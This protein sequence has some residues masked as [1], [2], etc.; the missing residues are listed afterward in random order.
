MD[1]SEASTSDGDSDAPNLASPGFLERGANLALETMS[2]KSAGCFM[3][4]GT[5]SEALHNAS[6]ESRSSMTSFVSTM[7]DLARLK[8]LKTHTG[9]TGMSAI[10]ELELLRLMQVCIS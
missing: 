3:Q 9:C 7:S 6:G 5:Y 8:Y 1:A 10:G 2:A 4:E